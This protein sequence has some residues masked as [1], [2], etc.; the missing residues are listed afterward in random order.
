MNHQS[1]ASQKL[2][3]LQGLRF[4]AAACIIWSH[5]KALAGGSSNPFISTAAGSVGVDIFFVISGFVISLASAKLHHNYRLFFAHRIARIVPLYYLLTC[6]LIAQEFLLSGHIGSPERLWNSFFFIPIFD[7]S[8][9]TWP[10]HY[11]GWTLS[12]EMW[13]YLAFGVA[14]ALCGA[15]RARVFIPLL[16]SGAVLLLYLFYDGSWMAPDFAFNPMVLEFCA[17]IVLFN[18]RNRLRAAFPL[19]LLGAPLLLYGV[20]ASEMLGWHTTVLPDRFLSLARALIWGGF[21]TCLVGCVVHLDQE[22]RIPVPRFML[23]LGDASYSIYLIQPFL[24]SPALGMFPHNGFLAC[25]VFVFGSILGGLL[26]YR[27]LEKPLAL[28]ARR[29]FEKL[30]RARKSDSPLNTPASA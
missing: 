12:Y 11:F 1:A 10:Y 30:L 24:I 6:L 4:V 14:I 19:L 27:F 28:P 2:E 3:G 17:G 22:K 9:Y 16:L 20:I 15:A 23:L 29:T 13:F 21:A 5:L 25:A 8:Q 18:C 7:L 26:L